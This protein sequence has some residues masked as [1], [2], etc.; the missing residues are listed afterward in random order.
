MLSQRDI[1]NPRL[2]SYLWPFYLLTFNHLIDHLGSS[3]EASCAFIFFF[4]PSLTDFSN[5]VGPKVWSLEQ[6]QLHPWGGDLLE[7]QIL[8]PWP[9][10]TQS[11]TLGVEASKLSSHKPYRSFWCTFEFENHCA[12]GNPLYHENI[13]HVLGAHG[14]KFG[15]YTQVWKMQGEHYPITLPLRGKHYLNILIFFFLL[16]NTLKSSLFLFIRMTAMLSEWFGLQMVFHF[17]QSQNSS[18]IPESILLLF[19]NWDI[20]DI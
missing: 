14:R 17:L 8:R 18:W 9:K 10:P 6:Q 15:K 11:E 3:F 1:V 16:K 13:I 19:K 2:K 4:F 12:G 7:M 5:S 20:F